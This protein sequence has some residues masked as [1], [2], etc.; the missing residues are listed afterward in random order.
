[1]NGRKGMAALIGGGALVAMG[2]IGVAAG[3]EP[4]GQ[5]A[6]VSDGSMST[7]QTTTMTYTG[8]VAPIVAGPVVKAKAYGG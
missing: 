4:A 7:G 2:V 8:T 1:M 6:V 5:T 3:G